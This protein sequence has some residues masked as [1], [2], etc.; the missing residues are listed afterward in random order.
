MSQAAEKILLVVDPQDRL[1]GSLT[2][3]DIRRS[4]LKA[5][6]LSI[7]ISGAYNHHP[8]YVREDY[9]LNDVKQMMLKN[10]I[11][12]I[13]VVNERHEVCDILLW[14]GVFGQDQRPHREKIGIP[15]LIMAGGK[16][17]RLDPFTRIL[18]KP[19][20]PIGE[21]AI[22]EVI[23]DKFYHYGV[24]EFYVTLNH[25]SRMIKAY[26][27][28][29]NTAY[30]IH[31]V[32]ED[33]PLG[34][35]GALTF[36]RDKIKDHVLVSNCDIIIENDYLEIVKFHLTQD[37]DMTIVGSFRHFT[38]P[39]GICT[40]ENGGRLKDIK[41]KPEYDFLVNTGMYILKKETI[42]LIPKKTFFN[43]TDL[44][45]RILEREGRI[46]VFPIDEKSWIDIGQWE[47]L[48]KS[49]RD[50]KLDHIG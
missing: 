37:Y 40:I 34:T 9:D 33:Q 2:D 1:L 29:I 21:K 17:S 26:F 47:E 43:I 7:E 22:I 23:M 15:V 3:G 13:P 32:E 48:Q 12:W 50:L 8:L 10:K 28:E 24:D 11:E 20:I 5:N 4:I 27:D 36:I 49:L 18:P 45:Q 41:E 39:Y 30:R 42:D 31:Y 38:I 44:V 16:G 19:L 35:A 46:G 14:A 6:D 25:K